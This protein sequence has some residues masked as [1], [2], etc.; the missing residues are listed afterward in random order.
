[1]SADAIPAA[2]SYY[3]CTL[4]P[5][6]M[7][8][9]L[10]KWARMGAKY[11]CREHARQMAAAYGT[12]KDGKMTVGAEVYALATPK[13]RTVAERRERAP[14]KRRTVTER[15]ADAPVDAAPAPPLVPEPTSPPAPQSQ[16]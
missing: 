8:V 6:Y 12:F 10:G 7:F 14:R 16:P 5:S 1:M 11:G 3:E 4:P 15:R 9:P 13:K 2:C